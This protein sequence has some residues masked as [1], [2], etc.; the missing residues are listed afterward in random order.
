M[1]SKENNMYIKIH[2]AQNYEAFM[3]FFKCLS[4]VSEITNETSENLSSV[5]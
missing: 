2:N 1:K 3:Q 4:I 5:Y